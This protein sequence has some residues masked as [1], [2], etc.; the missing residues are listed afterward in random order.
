MDVAQGMIDASYTSVF[1]GTKS[2]LIQCSKIQMAEEVKKQLGVDFHF[3]EDT[4][5]FAKVVFEYEKK[6]DTN[7]SN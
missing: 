1:V 4:N 2:L 6:G 5:G 3:E 7:E